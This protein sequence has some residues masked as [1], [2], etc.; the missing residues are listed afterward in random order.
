ME[1]LLPFEKIEREEFIRRPAKTDPKFGLDPEFRSVETLLDFGVM[2]FNK[3]SG[4]TSHQVSAYAKEI[5]GIKKGG[6]SG[7]LDPK[8]TGVLPVA[9]GRGTKV[10][11]TLLPAGKEYICI[12]H[13]HDDIPEDKIR[14]SMMSFVGKIKQLPPIKSSV[15]RE[16]RYRK[17]YYLDI[18]EIDGRDV[19]F[20]VGCQAGTYIRK[21]CTDMGAKMDTGAH[22]AELIRTKAGPF[23][24]SDMYT[25]QELRDAIYYYKTEA[26]DKFIRQVIKPLEYAVR[27]LPKVYILDS[28][29]EAL[30][31]GTNLAVP[32]IHKVESEIQKDELIAVMTMKNELVAIGRTNMISKEMVKKEKGIAVNIAKV[33]MEPRTY[34]RLTMS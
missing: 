4:P 31:H 24:F 34:P 8:V 9:I 33:F 21:L 22:M 12:M 18:I 14:E 30:C 7:T 11:Q 25:L 23:N 32:G 3:P 26:N 5:L 10:L 1:N 6:H 16:W 13:I 27:H 2:C 17:I 28:T 20:R 15:K 29:V 19:L